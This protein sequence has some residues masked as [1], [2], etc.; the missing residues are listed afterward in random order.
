MFHMLFLLSKEGQRS[1]PFTNGASSCRTCLVPCITIRGTWSLQQFL[2]PLYHFLLYYLSVTWSLKVS[3]AA[4]PRISYAAPSG[5][6][7]KPFW[8]LEVLGKEAKLS[9]NCSYSGPTY[10]SKVAWVTLQ[11]T[12][13]S[14][15][16]FAPIKQ[17]E[18]LPW[19]LQT[20]MASDCV[21]DVAWSRSLAQEGDCQLITC[22]IFDHISKAVLSS[23]LYRLGIAGKGWSDLQYKVQNFHWSSRTCCTP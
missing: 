21:S 8:M 20:N 2:R 19:R 12:T 13:K 3:R 4:Q 15:Q 14:M 16:G 5:L 17:G 18:F 23:Q 7:F 10:G 22:I 6:L 11:V 1:V 9:P